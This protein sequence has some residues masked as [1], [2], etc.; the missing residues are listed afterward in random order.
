[1]LGYK[2]KPKYNEIVSSLQCRKLVRHSD[3]SVEEWM[4]RLRVKATECKYK[5]IEC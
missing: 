2:L 3:E 1:M 4:G 5:E